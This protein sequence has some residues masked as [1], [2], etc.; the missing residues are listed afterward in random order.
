[1]VCRVLKQPAAGE[2]DLAMEHPPE[3]GRI[4]GSLLDVL[5][6]TWRRTTKT[7]KWTANAASAS[8]TPTRTTATATAAPV[9]MVAG[10]YWLQSAVNS[11]QSDTATTGSRYVIPALQRW[12]SEQTEANKEL[13]RKRQASRSQECQAPALCRDWQLRH[14]H[15]WPMRLPRCTSML[16]ARRRRALRHVM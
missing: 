2:H 16:V 11:K 1:M 14:W 7:R 3:S 6:A 8:A 15:R 12:A 9:R 5:P 10:I 13:C 4:V